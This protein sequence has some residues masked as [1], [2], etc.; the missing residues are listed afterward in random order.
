MKIKAVEII[1][2][3]D[4]VREKRE[5]IQNKALKIAKN[6]EVKEENN[7]KKFVI[8]EE[9]LEKYKKKK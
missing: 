7:E 4:E 8:K 9:F 1:Y 2:N 6:V 3:M 5:Y